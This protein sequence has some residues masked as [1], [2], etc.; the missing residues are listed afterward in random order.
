MNPDT[1]TTVA[2]TGLVVTLA[3]LA[4]AVVAMCVV[5]RKAIA[6]G[7]AAVGEGA[8][9]AAAWL[10][11]LALR[12][13]LAVTVRPGKNPYTGLT[14]DASADRYVT[15]LHAEQPDNWLDPDDTA[16]IP[17]P[18]PALDTVRSRWELV[19]EQHAVRM[20]E[21]RARG[22]RLL[23][24]RGPVTQE[25]GVITEKLTGLPLTDVGPAETWTQ[26]DLFEVK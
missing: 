21:A 3:L 16:V 20:D 10:A 18:W 15:D 8:C 17:L 2:G 13:Y 22:M 1:V 24:D 26:A 23:V 25:F 7:L 5:E 12:A 9:R 19:K 6:D 4:A 11:A 14:T